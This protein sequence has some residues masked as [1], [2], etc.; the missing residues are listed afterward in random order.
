M[1][2]DILVAYATKHGST[3][4]VAETVAAQ[5]GELGLTVELLPV[6][7]V[8]GVERYGAVV[9]GA[10]LYMG[11]WLGDA[12]RFLHHNREGLARTP[13]AV[14]ALGPV[15]DTEEQF[16]AARTQLERALGKEHELEPAEVAVFGG[17]IHQA[18]QHFPFSRMPEAD[19]RD[20]DAIR[21]W[22][23]GLPEALG[24]RTAQRAS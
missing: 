15:A 1:A 8:T 4:E 7:D 23:L 21:V 13:F 3:R 17:V 22:V 5:L 11:R 10:P 20:W 16:A 18:E 14:F 2:T 24:L 12:R 6:R 9:I 19:I